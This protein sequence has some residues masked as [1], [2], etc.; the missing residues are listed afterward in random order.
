MDLI[1]K[2]VEIKWR[3]NGI[4]QDVG[5]ELMSLKTWEDAFSLHVLWLWGGP[6][7]FEILNIIWRGDWEPGQFFITFL[8]YIH[9]GFSRND[10]EF[11]FVKWA[12]TL[13]FAERRIKRIEY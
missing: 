8:S 2:P 12:W 11:S 3:H 10:I 13:E 1:I 5:L 9:F 7:D 4:R 6:F